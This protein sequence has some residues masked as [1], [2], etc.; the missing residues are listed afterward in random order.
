MGEFLM[1]DCNR[2][3]VV[4]AVNDTAFLKDQD[5]LT[6]NQLQDKSLV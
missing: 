1:F 2:I 6:F 3:N 4:H 5:Y